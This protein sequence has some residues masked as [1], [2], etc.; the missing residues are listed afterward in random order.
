MNDKKSQSNHGPV[1]VWFRKG[2]RIHDNLALASAVKYATQSKSTILPVFTLDPY[3]LD[4]EKVGAV[5]LSFLLESLCDLD[6][7]L[8]KFGSALLL[9]KG[10]PDSVLID[11]LQSKNASALYFERDSEPYAKKRDAEIVQLCEKSNVKVFT[12]HGH[13]LFDLEYLLKQCTNKKAPSSMP[14]FLRLMDSVGN[15]ETPLSLERVLGV[16]NTNEKLDPCLQIPAEYLDSDSF[17]IPKS[18]EDDEDLVK[19]GYRNIDASG[20][21]FKGGESEA[22]LML[23]S[24]CKRDSGKAV[25][26]FSKPHTSPC[27]FDPQSTTGLSAYLKFGCISARRFFHRI[28]SKAKT[29]PPVSLVGQL[30]WREHFYLLGYAHGASFSTMKGNAL[31]RQ[32][33]WRTTEEEPDF[34]RAW[35]EGRTG[36]PWIDACMRQLRQEGWLHHLA[37][38]SVACF[39]T[40]G[41]L[42]ISWE[43]GQ[44]VFDRY[45]IDADWSINAANWMWL[46]CSAFFHQYFRVYSPIAFPKKYDK[47]GHF[48]RKYVPELKDIPDKYIYEPWNAP[49]DVQ[50]KAKC[51]V[52]I[53]YPRPIVDHSVASKQN[54]DRMSIAFAANKESNASTSKTTPPTKRMK[55]A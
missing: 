17:K 9:L 42:W 11:F 13:T 32:I 40:R 30:Y 15:P 52:G 31:C 44:K 34:A 21:K 29:Q 43:F 37:R 22:L 55:K 19:S 33:D 46:S 12:E 41:D 49:A 1:V 36:F 24:F 10:S 5:R 18:L 8:K 27:A 4:P 6:L 2:L 28:V 25:E 39:L 20:A 54:M 38:H 14:E 53:D 23:E 3:F 48:V 45:L 51:V 35:E 7:N 50:K 47:S 26:Q 16:S